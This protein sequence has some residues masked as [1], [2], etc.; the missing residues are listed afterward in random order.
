MSLWLSTAVAAFAATSSGQAPP[1]R[2]PSNQGDSAE[3]VRHYEDGVTAAKLGRWAKAHES[4]LAAWKVKQHFQIAANLG[5]AELKLRKYRDAAEHLAFFLREATGVSSQEDRAARKMLDEARA[6]VGA[7]TIQVNRADAEILV[8]GVAVGTAPIAHEVFVE[9]GR[10]TVEAK[11]GGFEDD[12]RSLDITAGSSQN[13]VL[14][15]SERPAAP[16]PLFPARPAGPSEKE[17][18]R[19]SV[20]P[21]AVGIGLTAAAVGVGIGT[22]SRGRRRGR[23]PRGFTRST[24]KRPPR[25][26]ARRRRLSVARRQTMRKLRPTGQ[27]SRMS[28]SGASSAPEWSGSVP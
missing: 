26:L 10:R 24:R 15:L 18:G 8:D 22:L 4:F 1:D 7:V 11:L 27:G 23:R 17:L 25:T 13:V 5:R 12:R 9:P 19:P 16:A 20:A 3:A 21:I 28:P 14:T 6:K 2:P